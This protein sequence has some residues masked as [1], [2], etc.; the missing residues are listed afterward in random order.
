MQGG[1]STHTRSLLR[2]TKDALIPWSHVCPHICSQERQLAMAASAAVA[3][4]ML[5]QKL[6]LQG[7]LGRSQ[8]AAI[9]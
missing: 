3:A 8:A 6:R 5:D 2:Q 4:S 7:S 1:T 9:L